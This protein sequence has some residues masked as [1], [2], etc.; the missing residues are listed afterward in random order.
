[1]FY[2]Y[3]KILDFVWNQY[4]SVLQKS[5]NMIF[6]VE[7]RIQFIGSQLASSGSGNI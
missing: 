1:M 7:P 4:I 6:F 2:K 5:K 3:F